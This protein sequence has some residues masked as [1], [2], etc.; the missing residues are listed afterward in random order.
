MAADRRRMVRTLP[1]G[2]KVVQDGGKF[3]RLNVP[4]KT[5]ECAPCCPESN[6][7]CEGKFIPYPPS[8]AIHLRPNGSLTFPAI[9]WLRQ[10]ISEEEWVE[11]IGAL[12]RAN[13]EGTVQC[14]ACVYFPC[15]WPGLIFQPFICCLPF[16]YVAGRKVASE[17][18]MNLA[19]A[20]YNKHLFLPRG[21]LIRRQ[22]EWHKFAPDD[23]GRTRYTFLRIDLLPDFGVPPGEVIDV[24]RLP[25]PLRPGTA[26]SDLKAQSVSALVSEESLVPF[27]GL[28]PACTWRQ[29]VPDTRY[30]YE[31]DEPELADEALAARMARRHPDVQ[32]MSMVRA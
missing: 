8:T 6:L 16:Q 7:C 30:Y 28:F 13:L 15:V 29:C 4:A 5:R 31:G 14:R 12:D 24:R 10:R 11:F 9:Q 22:V 23:D 20:K 3:V 18:A 21:L 1:K 17:N 32:G 25:E 27:V 2:V 19:V 26:D